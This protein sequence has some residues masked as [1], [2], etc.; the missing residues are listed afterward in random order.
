MIGG[1]FWGEESEWS[2]RGSGDDGRVLM[3]TRYQRAFIDFFE[4]QLVSKKYD[5]KDLIEEFLLGGKEPLINGLI[6]GCTNTSPGSI[7]LAHI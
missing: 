4:D 7:L 6:S 3:C 2:R 1:T 5:L